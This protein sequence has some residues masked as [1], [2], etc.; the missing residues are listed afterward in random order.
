MDES[1]GRPFSRRPGV[2]GPVNSPGVDELLSA[3]GLGELD[4][5]CRVLRNKSLKGVS[6]RA[7]L[8]GAWGDTDKGLLL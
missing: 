7:V 8:S 6:A 4:V 5:F 3:E 2:F 1:V